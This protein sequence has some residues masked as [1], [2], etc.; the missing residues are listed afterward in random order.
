MK[1]QFHPKAV[2]RQF[3]TY[4]DDLENHPFFVAHKNGTNFSLNTSFP[5]SG[6]DSAA[7]NFDEIHLESFLTRLRQLLFGGELFEYARLIE[8]VKTEFGTDPQFEK[9]SV[10]L[11]LAIERKYPEGSLKAYKP[12]G[13][14]II[15]GRTFSE[16]IEAE[17]YSG[18]IHSERTLQAKPGSSSEGVAQSHLAVRKHLTFTLAGSSLKAA[19]NV[20][21]LRNHVLRLARL[22]NQ[23]TAFPELEKFDKRCRDSGF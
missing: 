16:L 2:L 22:R 13:D 11:K 8:L 6:A 10:D 19:S 4:C 18:K 21:C 9:F 23:A 7:L 20:F 15:V 12:N 5:E 3:L 1:K 17:L 14:D